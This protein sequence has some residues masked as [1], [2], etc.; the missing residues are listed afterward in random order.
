M[1]IAGKLGQERGVAM[2]TVIVVSAVIMVLGGGMYVLASR[3]NTIT[4][5]D[6]VGGQAFYHAE[7]GLENTI[8]V[9][10]YSATE[11]QLTRARAD[12][13]SDGYG[14]LMDPNPASRQNPTDPVQMDI[15]NE[16]FTVW[17]D[18]V[19]ADGNHCENCG[20]N[21]AGTNPAYLLITAEGR[22]SEGYR[23]VQQQVRVQAS[24]FPMA[25]YIEGDA[26]MI[27]TPEVV[28]Q[29]V[30]IKGNFYGRKY[31][32]VTGQD[33]VYG[34][35]AGVFATGS[36]Y[37][38]K[39]NQGNS[40]I[41][42]SD[43]QHSS[44]WESNFANDRDSRGPAGNTFTLTDLNDLFTTSGLTT[45][46]LTTLK[47]MAIA[48]GYYINPDS[49]G[50]MIRQQDLPSHDGDI[51]VYVEYSGGSPASNLVDLNFTWP[52][53][54]PDG[55]AMIIVRNGSVKMNG[56][57]IGNLQ[58]YVYCPDGPIVFRGGGQG[59]Y[60][61][62]VWGKGIEEQSGSGNFVFNMTDDFLMDPPF[63][64]WTVVRMTEWT[65]VDR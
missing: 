16:S 39:E 18:L 10:N 19:D 37:A 56:N 58:G 31:L 54:Y 61:G 33:Q 8:D 12:Q 23:K 51:V 59:N 27:G 52:D 60:T 32:T 38:R 42:T 13:S 14:Y 47:G 43:G 15:G 62:T 26:H 65:E 55:K 4:R 17:V 40:Q 5:A 53:A 9:L 44:Y 48:N 45:A 50:L 41:Y 28:G 24:G 2:I 49:G 64:A 30:Y 29:S 11:T 20:L 57:D 3:E 46:Q 1:T 36:I 22:S 7:G 35:A 63:F 6:R 34:G 25:L 21:L